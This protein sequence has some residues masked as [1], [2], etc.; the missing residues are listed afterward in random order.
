VVE[1]NSVFLRSKNSG[2]IRQMFVWRCANKTAAACARNE[3]R[4]CGFLE[5]L[6]GEKQ[7]FKERLQEAAD[8][9]QAAVSLAAAVIGLRGRHCLKRRPEGS[10]LAR[11]DDRLCDRIVCAL[12][13][14][15]EGCVE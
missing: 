13:Y 8:R 10:V 3:K 2:M 6:I 14:Q 1:K 5:H 7:V 12:F 9:L 15:C 4:A 11:H